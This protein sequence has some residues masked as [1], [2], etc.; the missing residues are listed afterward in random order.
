MT[1]KLTIVQD[2]IEQCSKEQ[3]QS[4][5]APIADLP[6]TSTKAEMISHCLNK[7]LGAYGFK[8][9]TSPDRSMVLI[10]DE[11]MS[12]VVDFFHGTG[13]KPYFTKEHIERIQ[14]IQKVSTDNKISIYWA[15]SG[16]KRKYYYLKQYGFNGLNLYHILNLN[17]VNMAS[18]AASSTG[19]ATLTMSGIVAVELFLKILYQHY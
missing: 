11:T 17:T 8:S 18:A 3:L 15:Q 13:Y 19:A 2:T 12:K 6:N 7:E 16:F 10:N 4:V 5:F 14:A 9:Y 1:T